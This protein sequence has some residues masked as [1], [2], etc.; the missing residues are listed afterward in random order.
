MSKFFI[1]TEKH[2]TLPHVYNTLGRR[3]AGRCPSCKCGRP[4]RYVSFND[5]I[6]AE[7]EAYGKVLIECC[8]RPGVEDYEVTQYDANPDMPREEQVALIFIDG[9]CQNNGKSD[10]HAGIGVYWGELH[11][12]WNV[13]DRLDGPR[14]TNNCAEIRAAICAIEQ[15]KEYGFKGAILMTDSKFMIDCVEKYMPGGKGWI[16]N[17]WRKPDG[18]AVVNKDE[19]EELDQVM[20]GYL[21]KM[22]HVGRDSGIYGNVAADNL[23]KSGSKLPR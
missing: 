16:A 15:A 19:L 22:I 8:A 18:A 10:A 7:K 21:V 17:D 12:D 23:A 3:Y 5:L 1:G 20:Q 13:S 11:S 14:Q 9:A 2:L 4:L 6:F